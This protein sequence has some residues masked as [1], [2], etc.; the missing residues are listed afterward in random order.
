[1]TETIFEGVSRLLLY[2]LRFLRFMI[3][4]PQRGT[5]RGSYIIGKSVHNQRVER[6]KHNAFHAITGLYY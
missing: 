2:L 1:M 3:S 4:Q 6:L 5:D